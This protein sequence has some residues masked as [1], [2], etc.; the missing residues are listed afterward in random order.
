MEVLGLSNAQRGLTSLYGWY[1]S[2]YH[3]LLYPLIVIAYLG[4]LI[5]ANEQQAHLARSTYSSVTTPGYERCY[6]M[7]NPQES[8]KCF[9]RGLEAAMCSLDVGKPLGFNSYLTGVTSA[10]PK[11]RKPSA[12]PEVACESPVPGVHL[13]DLAQKT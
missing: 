13:T 9:Y 8:S 6:S 2:R 11:L 10:L 12:R 5:G 4:L 1:F 3:H 7:V